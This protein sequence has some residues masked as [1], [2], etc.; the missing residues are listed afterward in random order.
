MNEITHEQA[1][2]YI[3]KGK[4]FLEPAQL[5]ALATHLRGCSDCQGYADLQKMLSAALSYTMHDRWDR[6]LPP[7]GEEFEILSR[8]RRN[9]MFRHAFSFTNAIILVSVLALGLFA[10]LIWA[11]PPATQPAL[12]PTTLPSTDTKAT[13]VLPLQLD[14]VVCS[15]QA[16]PAPQGVYLKYPATKVIGGGTVQNSDFT[17]QIYLY[18]NDALSPDTPES[19]SEIGGL[20]IHAKWVYNGPL[21]EGEF[22]DLFGIEPG[23]KRSTGFPNLSKRSSA[24]YDGGLF[25]PD[26]SSSAWQVPQLVK[27]GR[28]LQF[29][30]K[31]Q[32]K[33]MLYG[34]GLTFKLVKGANGYMPVEIEVRALPVEMISPEPT[35]PAVNGTVQLPPVKTAINRYPA[36]NGLIA[37]VSGQDGNA[38]IYTMN[39]DGSQV[40]N[41]TQNPAKDTYPVWSPDGKKIAFLANRTGAEEVFLMNADGSG[42]RQLTKDSPSTYLSETGE[43]PS[44]YM[45]LSWSPDG[46]FLLAELRVGVGDFENRLAVIKTDG[47]GAQY[48]EGGLFHSPRWSPDGSKIAF[49][50]YGGH[51]V[52]VI[53][54]DAYELIK[55]GKVRQVGITSSPDWWETA[56]LR[57]SPDASSLSVIALSD[58]FQTYNIRVM[59]AKGT[60]Q[61]SI[62]DFKENASAI[63]TTPVWTPD[64]NNIVFTHMGEIY[65]VNVDGSDLRHLV[66]MNSPIDHLG[67]SPDGDFILFSAGDKLKQVYSLNIESALQSPES[68]QPVRLT[69][70]SGPSAD[71]PD[72][73][74]VPL[75]PIP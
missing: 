10:A 4:A 18:C 32:T 39:P 19:F 7:S 64:S 53:A 46:S 38:E 47:T 15:S 35:P 67:L 33:D 61:N 72:W 23:V 20:G 71:L 3:H 36:S 41:L 44:N 27:E 11:R 70:E 40:T 13:T 62:Y 43:L 31:V 59:S 14:P 45:D 8:A 57:W 50:T 25:F 42:V 56:T 73:Q 51:G 65:I 12:S 54:W 52:S 5:D 2:E 29:S 24:G 69:K 68:T 66:S 28:P 60:D 30:M 17:F 22:W 49:L 26:A 34:A 37:Y 6:Y 16:Y 74:P 58:I 55:E 75:L 9:A 21:L 1:Y 63:F 48:F